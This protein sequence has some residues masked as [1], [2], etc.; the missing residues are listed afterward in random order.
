MLVNVESLAVMFSTIFI[1]DKTH[2]ILMNRNILFL[3]KVLPCLFVSFVFSES[4]HAGSLSY[5]MI[6]HNT[7]FLYMYMK[8]PLLCYPFVWKIDLAFGCFRC[9]KSKGHVVV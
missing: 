1:I 3:L 8:A 6:L 2:R 5:R 4:R 9:N 7:F